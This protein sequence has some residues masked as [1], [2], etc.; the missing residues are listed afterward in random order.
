MTK[1][2]TFLELTREL[3]TQGTK[4]SESMEGQTP[5]RR[6]EMC[7][8]DVQSKGGRGV[9]HHTYTLTE[10]MALLVSRYKYYLSQPL[11]FYIRYLTFNQKL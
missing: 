3:R 8:P 2:T 4:Q 1:I 9:S 10:E 11:L 7:R 6:D 5:S